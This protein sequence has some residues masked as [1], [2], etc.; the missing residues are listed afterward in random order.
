MATFMLPDILG[1]CPFALA[2][3]PH[4]AAVSPECDAWMEAS[5]ALDDP[6]VAKR[7][8]VAGFN[9]L[10]ALCFPEADRERFRLCCDY[11]NALFAW[12]DVIDDGELRENVEG[13]QHAVE[14]VMSALRDPENFR[15]DCVAAD[16]LRDFWLRARK[17]AS[18]GC[19][20]RFLRT[21]DS[22]AHAASQ[23]VINRVH[24]TDLD[25]DTY[26]KLRR[27]VSALFPVWT[28]VELSLG[29]DLPDEVAHH[30]VVERLGVY[31]N[32]LVALCNDVYSFN[33]EQASGHYSN[34]VPITMAQLS[35]PLQRAVDHVGR[36]IE[37]TFAAF[38]ADKS[39]LPSWT[40]EIDRQVQAYVRGMESWVVGS[41]QWSFDS[42]RYFGKEHEEVKRTL[43]VR[44]WPKEVNTPEKK[45]KKVKARGRA[46]AKQV[47][48]HL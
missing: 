3:N 32:D 18:P 31:A 44:L 40:P 29:L 27:D 24:H 21:M 35:L 20:E 6:A 47:A 11:I 4:L 46:K 26:I 42:N 2:V 34:L 1:Y 7:Y 19:Q 41:I 25:I 9:Y 5:G 12:D 10:T 33:C 28:V 14:N 8:R 30:P 22:Y 36:R 13:A 17:V 38:V 45:A 37:S 16:M 43:C 48:A 23:Q 39:Q 15:P